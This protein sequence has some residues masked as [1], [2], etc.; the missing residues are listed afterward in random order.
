MANEDILRLIGLCKK[1]GRLEVGE[2]PAGAACRARQARV[3]LLAGDAAPNTFRRA[4]HFGEA[5][6]VLWLE[7]PFTKSELGGCVGRTSCAMAAVTDVGFA[8]SIVKKLQAQDPERYEAAEQRLSRQAEKALQ[9]QREQRRHEKNL[10]MGKR[11]P[12]APPPKAAEGKPE[13]AGAR[14]TGKAGPAK[15][16]TARKPA[17]SGK[18]AAPRKATSPG[19]AAAPGRRITVRSRRSGKP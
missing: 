1:A 7:L 15:G 5:G 17:G 11:R 13:G 9:R 3:L 6:Q 12:W 4:A 16:K 2:E 18:G 10:Q 19:K 14:R 8:A